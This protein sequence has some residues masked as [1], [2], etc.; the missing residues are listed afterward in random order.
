MCKSQTVLVHSVNCNKQLSLYDLTAALLQREENKRSSER[1]KAPT[2]PHPPRCPSIQQE[3][4]FQHHFS[5][6]PTVVSDEDRRSGVSLVGHRPPESHQVLPNDHSLT[7]SRLRQTD[8]H[9]VVSSDGRRND[10]RFRA[11][12]T[13]MAWVSL[14]HSCVAASWLL[15]TQRKK[16]LCVLFILD[17]RTANC[18]RNATQAEV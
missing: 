18:E 17:L 6:L 12:R 7:H 13:K 3:F 11:R 10:C 15:G 9:T 4:A 1:R 2:H 16:R 5:L 14:L 8:R